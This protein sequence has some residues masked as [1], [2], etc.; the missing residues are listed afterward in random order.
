MSQ[1]NKKN[2]YLI[3]TGL[4]FELLAIGV[5]SVFIGEIVEGSL[6][7]K[8]GYG[9][10]LLFIVLFSGWLVHLFHLLKKVSAANKSDEPS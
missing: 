9:V 6:E 8:K 2:T 1:K 10:L 5:A 7:W 3:F 4:G